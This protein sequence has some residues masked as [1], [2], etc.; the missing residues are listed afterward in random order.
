MSAERARLTRFLPRAALATLALIGWPA[1]LS[2]APPVGAPATASTRADD[3]PE[4]PNAGAG[5]GVAPVPGGRPPRE[6]RNR[7]APTEAEWEAAS[8][9]MKSLA[10]NAWA[11]LEAMPT[12]APRRGGIMRRMVDRHQELARMKERE[13]RRYE[14]EVEQLRVEDDILGTVTKLRA[15]GG[16]VDAAV[17][18]RREL[19]EQVARLVDLRIRNRE[20]RIARLAQT[21]E[22]ERARLEADK[23]NKEQMVE[24][25]FKA[26]LNGRMGRGAYFGAPGGGSPAGGG[27]RRGPGAPSSPQEPTRPNEPAAK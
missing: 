21:L 17:P 2:A 8:G 7:R 10:P 24:K 22:A 20:A 3:Q 1:G 14:S 15:A 18:L 5:L 23:R 6:Y 13:P 27:P 19:R 11:R 12:D 25:K 26:V 4:R 9:S 16:N